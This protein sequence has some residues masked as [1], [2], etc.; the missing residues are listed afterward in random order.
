MPAAAGGKVTHHLL[1]GYRQA[2]ISIIKSQV[3]GEMTGLYQPGDYGPLD[4]AKALD[5]NTALLGVNLDPASLQDPEADAITVE[6]QWRRQED[7]DLTRQQSSKGS[8][9]CADS[10]GCAGGCGGPSGKHS[11]SSRHMDET[12]KKMDPTADNKV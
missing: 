4:L 12:V 9:S 10:G 2:I 3:T 5:L 11:Q 8:F 1:E 7:T 6:E